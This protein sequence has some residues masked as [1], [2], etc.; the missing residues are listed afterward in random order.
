MMPCTRGWGMAD[1]TPRAF[2][3][4]CL[5]FLLLRCSVYIWISTAYT[6]SSCVPFFRSSLPSAV[7][8]DLQA[9][10]AGEGVQTYR[11]KQGRSLCVWRACSKHGSS[12]AKQLHVST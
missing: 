9:G 11:V 6:S 12:T 2:W 4:S 5:S 8:Q 1:L 3:Y 10:A 7:W